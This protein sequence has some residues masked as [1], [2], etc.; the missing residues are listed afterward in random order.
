MHP[1]KTRSD[2]GDPEQYVQIKRKWLSP[3]VTDCTSHMTRTSVIMHFYGPIHPH[4]C[5]MLL[6]NGFFFIETSS[7][8]KLPTKTEE[9]LSASFHWQLSQHFCPSNFTHKT[10]VKLW[11]T[12]Q[13]FSNSVVCWDH[14]FRTILSR[15]QL[16]DWFE[17]WNPGLIVRMLTL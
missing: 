13:V 9:F 4:K 12:F 11:F 8:D 7:L 6:G 3:S 5:P 17:I 15:N 10:W 1:Y 2:Y 14:L 16:L